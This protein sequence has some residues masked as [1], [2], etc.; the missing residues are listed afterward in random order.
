MLF[1]TNDQFVMSTELECLTTVAGADGNRN[2]E[3]E[4]AIYRFLEIMRGLAPSLM[5]TAGI[6]NGYG[7]IYIDCSHIELAAIE[8]DSPYFLAQ[9]VE[10]QQ[11]LA[12][13]A[14]DELKSEGCHLLLANNNHSGLLE[15]GCAIWG[16]HENYMTEKHPAEFTDLI[17][18]FLITRIFAGAGGV[19]SPTG[20]F[21]AAVRPIR[22]EQATGGGTTEKRAIHST[23]REEHHMGPRS[24]RFRYHLILGDGH[25]SHFNLALQFGATALALKAV[26]FDSQLRKDI[27]K[28]GAFPPGDS[29]VKALRRLNILA[30][31]GKALQIHPL[32]I[33][34]QRVYLEAARRY[35]HSLKRPA[36]WI[37]RMLNDW[38][39]TLDAMERLNRPWLSSRLD[40]FAK[41]E[42]YTAV[43]DD[44]GKTWN[45]LAH[46]TQLFAE[47]A[48]LDHSFHAFC[49]P[50]S[51]F[52]HL[53]EA[54]VLDHRIGDAIRPGSEPEAFVP[55]TATRARARA[56]F[57]R[58]HC[59]R[60]SF[61]VD[62]S[63]AHDM[64]KNQ[65]CDLFDPFADSYSEWKNCGREPGLMV[66]LA[67]RLCW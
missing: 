57:I 22:M 63:W 35:V 66:Q 32:V 2:V 4:T 54:G 51:A 14:I 25:R 49:E 26:I 62:W 30:K 10:T 41:Y 65:Q 61:M 44:T 45:D 59:K 21:L 55:E 17:L 50:D 33:D 7:K 1:G 18:P 46:D 31:P 28:L 67:E 52:V 15:P 23:A 34:T 29:W 13:Q 58:D 24:K 47:L 5:A 36:A 6:F 56:R 27:A 60:G 43:L 9:V 37:P 16:S 11:L 8:C 64:E 19:Q 48:L 42:F 53:N 38:Q 3:V 40:A 20:L 39:Q 12:A